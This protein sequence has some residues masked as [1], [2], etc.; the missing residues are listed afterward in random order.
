MN[1]SPTEAVLS[2]F[3]QVSVANA[4]LLGSCFPAQFSMGRGRDGD[5]VKLS[6]AADRLV[7][8]D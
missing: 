6:R 7:H 8:I 3:Q 2:S 1:S 4:E 5:A